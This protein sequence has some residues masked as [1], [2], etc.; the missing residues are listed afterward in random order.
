MSSRASLPLT[1]I[2]RWPLLLALVMAA[3]LAAA[4]TGDG[5]GRVISW[6]ALGFPILLMAACILA[7]F[8]RQTKEAGSTKNGVAASLKVR[9]E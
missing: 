4:L 8:R 6:F 3:G 5:I 9:Q 1:A 2:Y 7:P